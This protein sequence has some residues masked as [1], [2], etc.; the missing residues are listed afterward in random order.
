[1]TIHCGSRLPPLWTVLLSTV[2][3]GA[4]PFNK[5]FAEVT[6]SVAQDKII[7]HVQVHEG[8]IRGFSFTQ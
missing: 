6:A 3:G 5:L 7:V 1:M 8:V 4:N 2:G